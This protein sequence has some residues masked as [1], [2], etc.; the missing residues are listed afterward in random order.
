VTEQAITRLE[1]AAP[2]GMPR[3]PSAIERHF[4][5]GSALLRANKLREAALELAAAAD[6]SEVDPLS[7]DA[8]YLQ[9]T[10]L[11]GAG[12]SAEAERAL[13]AFLDHA[14][15]ALRRGRAAVML[16]RLI[17][18]RGDVASARAW[19][20]SALSDPDRDV[21]AAAQAGLDQLPPR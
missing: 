12:Q 20:S 8:R 9:A 18:A 11:I 10:A 7:L 16:A 1:P 19:F 2:S 4:Q 14:P 15:R 3:R 5:A 13:V 21:A 6:A 17:A